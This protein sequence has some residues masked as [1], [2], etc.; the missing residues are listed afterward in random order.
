VEKKGVSQLD[1]IMSLALFLLYIIWF[2]VLIMPSLSST[3]TKDTFLS[4]L[5]TDFKEDFSW[6]LNKYP[7]FI[8][9][10]L[11][12]RTRPV[13]FNMTTNK[14]DFKFTDGLNY[15]FWK[16]KMIF[17]ANLSSQVTT[18]FLMEG[19]NYSNQTRNFETIDVNDD[20]V[21]TEN[22]TVRFDDS[23]VERIDYLGEEKIAG[24]TYKLNDITYS[25]LNATW[26]DS[27]F[28]GI[29]SSTTQ[30]IN[31]S[32]LVFAY[33][34]EIHN[35]ISTA[36]QDSNYT[37]VI[38]MNLKNYASYFSNNDYYGN[39]LYS[40]S[41]ANVNYSFNYITLYSSSDSL[42]MHF[43]DDVTFSFTDYNRTLKL[44]M[45]IPFRDR[46]SFTYIFHEGGYGYADYDSYDVRFGAKETVK[47][48]YLSN[49]STNYSYLKEK[50][51][52]PAGKEFNIQ[53]F[54]NTTSY[55]YLQDDPLYE[56]GSRP[57]KDKQV[58]AKS[59]DGYS[60]DPDGNYLPIA[61]NYRTW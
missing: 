35:F 57:A 24:L 58:I 39:F 7:I 41:T 1:W 3:F 60:L 29:Y 27:G 53:V 55:N 8:E 23:M 25:P 6:E 51:K 4:S 59:V 33:S 56:I 40:N 45:T 43:D 10:N 47:G 22:L 30:N 26:N 38:N 61:I 12:P 42:S 50:W 46:Y 9:Y 14:T 52:V 5:D 2:F 15:I 16:G 49:I 20:R 18:F 31:I 36:S 34:P 21:S 11:S 19:G 44:K 13:I 37:L 17:I 28:A 32:S 48:I 54:S